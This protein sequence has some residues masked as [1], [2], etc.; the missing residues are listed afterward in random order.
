MDHLGP[1]F[2]LLF[3]FFIYFFVSVFLEINLL[4][5]VVSGH[6]FSLASH[7][8]LSLKGMRGRCYSLRHFP[9][10]LSL[11]NLLESHFSLVHT[12]P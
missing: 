6:R 2:P 1:F 10:L 3:F 7:S 9:H 12:S 4:T 5:F 8:F 11:I